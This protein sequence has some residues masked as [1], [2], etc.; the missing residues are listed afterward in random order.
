M[1]ILE[2]YTFANL[3]I[4][5]IHSPPK[6]MAPLQSSRPKHAD[7]DILFQR[8]TPYCI[9]NFILCTCCKFAVTVPRVHVFEPSWQQQFEATRTGNFPMT[10]LA[11]PLF[12]YCCLY[13]RTK[14]KKRNIISPSVVSPPAFLSDLTFQVLYAVGRAIS[15]TSCTQTHWEVVSF[16]LNY[17][18]KILIQK[19]KQYMK[20]ISCMMLVR[21]LCHAALIP[22]H[23]WPSKL[24]KVIYE[25]R[26][27]P[28]GEEIMNISHVSM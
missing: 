27:R 20:S 28:W 24:H 6:T 25:D 12:S 3:K 7:F 5:L 10:V 2:S 18:K 4:L 21:T 13:Q 16:W 14:K 17:I 19:E 15:V 11:Y 22:R 8:K 23:D 9:Y 1:R 26:P